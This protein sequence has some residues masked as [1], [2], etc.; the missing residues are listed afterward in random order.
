MKKK[1][2]IPTSNDCLCSHFGHCEKFKI[3]ETA[4]NKIVKEETVTPPPHEPGV[5]PAW[6][7][8]KGVTHIIAGGIGQRAISLFSQNNIKVLY[9]VAEKPSKEIISDFMNG[10][11]ETGS[12]ACDH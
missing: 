4:D 10:K 12:N 11:L 6:L 2:A 3:I 1:I 8:E 7:A 9:G 5:F